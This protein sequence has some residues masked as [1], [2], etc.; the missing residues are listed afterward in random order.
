MPWMSQ[1]NSQGTPS[2]VMQLTMQNMGA[3]SYN[4]PR[5]GV[6]AP[7]PQPQQSYQQSQPITGNTVFQSAPP[8]VSNP[9]PNYAA[10]PSPLGVDDIRARL[11]ASTGGNVTPA[12]TDFYRSQFM[13]NPDG[14]P[15]SV[16][17]G[18]SG[19]AFY[20]TLK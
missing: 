15:Y 14:S 12:A 18:M 16:S 13:Y 4:T 19:D 17:S 11:F 1:F 3:N 7:A 5:P 8:D 10:N 6:S 9:A 20:N 2:P